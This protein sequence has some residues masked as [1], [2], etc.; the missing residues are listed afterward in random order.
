MAVNCLKCSHWFLVKISNFLDRVNGLSSVLCPV[1][2]YF[3]RLFL[4][5]SRDSVIGIMARLR[6]GRSAFETRQEQEIFSS[7]K[8]P[9]WLWCQYS[10]LLDGYHSSFPVGEAARA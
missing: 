10:L 2:L 6:A 7:P 4:R 9:D 3:S 8:R 5:G 1:S